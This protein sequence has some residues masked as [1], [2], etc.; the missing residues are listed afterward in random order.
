MADDISLRVGVQDDTAQPLPGGSRAS[1][2]AK[3]IAALTE[4]RGLNRKPVEAEKSY[5]GSSPRYNPKYAPRAGFFERTFSRKDLP[6]K[7]TNYDP[8]RRQYDVITS[9]RSFAEAY[10]HPY[11]THVVQTHGTSAE[12]EQQARG[13][14]TPVS[15]HGS[16]VGQRA[17]IGYLL[18][19]VTGAAIGAASAARKGAKLYALPNPVITPKKAMPTLL[20][21]S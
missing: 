19:G 11:G 1:Q 8:Q 5:K 3:E 17:G 20:P 16:D 14:S 9:K 7:V 13:F 10:S 6:Y 21:N 2:E 12:V 4:R 15:S 18:G